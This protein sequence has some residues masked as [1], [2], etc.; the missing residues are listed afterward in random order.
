MSEQWRIR[1]SGKPRREPNISLLVQ[2]ML[3]LG[4]ELQREVLEREP[5]VKDNEA[6]SDVT[7]HGQ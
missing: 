3:A 4:N 1:V 6:Q 2:A 5:A 7:E